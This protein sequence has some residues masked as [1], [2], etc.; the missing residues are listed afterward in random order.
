[1][2]SFTCAGCGVEFAAYGNASRKFCSHEC[3]IKSRF[4]GGQS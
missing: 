1:M 2:Y 3:Y 4:G